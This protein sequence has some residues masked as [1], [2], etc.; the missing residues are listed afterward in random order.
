[1]PRHVIDKDAWGGAEVF[2]ALLA[3]IRARRGDFERQRH[4][5]PDIIDRFKAM[6]VYRALVPKRYGGDEKSPLDFL[7]M[8]EAIAA[9]DGSAGWVASFGMNPAYLAALPPETVEKVWADGP[10][11]VFAGGIFPPQPAR[12][13]EG[14]YSVSGRWQF[15]SGCL[16]ATLCGVG[17]MPEDGQ[18]LP[19]MA[20]M[21]R[22]RLTIEP[23]W[24]VLGLV[25]TGSHDLVVEDVVVPEEWTFTRGGAPTVDAPF[26]RYPSL[27]FAAQVLSVVTLGLAREALDVVQDTANAR[28]SVTGAP[29]I[30][31]RPHVQTEIAKAEAKVRA[32]RAFFYEATEDAWQAVLDGGRPTPHQTSMLRLSTTHLTQECAEAVRSAYHLSGMTGTYN[33]HP[34][35]RLFRDAAMCTQHAFMGAITYQNAGAMFFGKKPLPGYL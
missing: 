16:G 26:F 20:V 28:A 17:I 22:D 19:R 10:D 27:A 32:A 12:K 35:S 23:N 24:D 34:L 14:G 3:D 5:S 29:N 13:V 9:A 6:G 2:D 11:V 18:S 1:M 25:G 33:A 31:D 15:A 21:P 7:L 8:V 4:I 30:G